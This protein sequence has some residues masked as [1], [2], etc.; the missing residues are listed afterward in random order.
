[1]RFSTE[2]ATE[3]AE[4]MLNPAGATFSCHNTISGSH[5]DA[6]YHPG[7]RD[8]HCAGALIFAEK[9]ENATQMMRIAERLGLYDASKLMKNKGITDLVFDSLDEMLSVQW[10]RR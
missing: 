8:R 9:H 3:I 1:M 6:D 4:N 7:K 2:R 5:A 10:D